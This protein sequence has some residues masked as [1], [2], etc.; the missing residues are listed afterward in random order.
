MF[1]LHYI[2]L[3][4]RVFDV[5]GL[6]QSYAPVLSLAL[7]PVQRKIVWLH[8][9]LMLYQRR[10]EASSFSFILFYYI[11]L[12][13]VECVNISLV[14][15]EV[16]SEHILR[17][18]KAIEQPLRRDLVLIIAQQNRVLLKWANLYPLSFQE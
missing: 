11:V 9:Q 4:H 7:Q 16:K 1:L 3:F 5:S 8:L 14:C 18:Y 10:I 6:H 15:T 13:L 12:E 17:L 2:Q